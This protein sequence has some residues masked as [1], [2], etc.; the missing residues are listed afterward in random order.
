M[1][2]VLQDILV[3]TY[4]PD[5]ALR[6]QAESALKNFIFAEGED[7][8]QY[9]AFLWSCGYIFTVQTGSYWFA[10]SLTQMRTPN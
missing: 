9:V 5:K 1:E 7:C 3:N 4:N 6:A 8:D 2:A 10:F